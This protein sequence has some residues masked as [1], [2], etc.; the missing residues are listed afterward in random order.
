[1]FVLRYF[2]DFRPRII[3]TY[4]ELQYREFRGITNTIIDNPQQAIEQFKNAR[5]VRS[6][7][8]ILLYGIAH[9]LIGMNPFF[10]VPIILIINL[11]L[12]F[13][14]LLFFYF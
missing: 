5:Y 10:K 9:A 6:A 4:P 8:A 11:F 13:I 12:N 3:D 2:S 1:M 14:Y 7:Y